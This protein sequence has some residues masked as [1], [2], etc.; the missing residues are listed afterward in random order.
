MPPASFSKSRAIG[1]DYVEIEWPGAL[2][3]D[4]ENL[5]HPL[6]IVATLIDI[7]LGSANAECVCLIWLV[8]FLH[9]NK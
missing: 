4:A 5:S 1:P 3:L 8:A 6:K 9:R 2:G 7:R